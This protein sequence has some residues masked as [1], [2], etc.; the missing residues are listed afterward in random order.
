MIAGETVRVL[1]PTLVG[2]DDFGNE[3]WTYAGDLDG[4]AWEGLAPYAWQAALGTT[5]AGLLGAWQALTAVPW[6]QAALR[7][8]GRAACTGG[9]LVVANALVN[10]STTTYDR[11][12]PGRPHGM[13]CDLTLYFP[14]EFD[15]DV[16]GAL[17]SLRG[18]TYRVV[19]DPER[20]TDANLPRGCQWNLVARV[21]RFDA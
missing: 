17:V 7:T 4:L 14:R 3:V 21:A 12:E 6:S 13:E 5:W 16:R 15:E 8:W 9:A 19:G 1:L 2:T 18:D 20:Y 11:N 10:P